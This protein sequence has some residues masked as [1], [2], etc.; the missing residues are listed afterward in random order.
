MALNTNLVSVWR[1]NESSGNPADSFG[2]NTLTNNGTTTFTTGKYANCADFGATNTTKYFSIASALI[3]TSTTGTC[4]IWWW[5]NISTAPASWTSY[6]LYS[7]IKNAWRQFEFK[8]E[9]SA[10]TVQL[11]LTVFDGTGAWSY[12]QTKTLTVW[13]WYHIMWTVNANTVS[14]YLNWVQLWSN[15]TITQVNNWSAVN[16]FTIGRHSNAVAWFSCSQADETW[17]WSRVLTSTEV[18]QVYSLGVYPWTSN[19]SLFLLL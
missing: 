1:M 3:D 18:Q 17:L 16:N 6:E 10:G 11:S 4:T 14:T 7:S 15:Q 2:A 5:V 13:T 9:N 8:Y 12:A 19:P